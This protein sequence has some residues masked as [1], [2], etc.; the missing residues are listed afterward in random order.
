MRACGR[1][2]G[3]ASAIGRDWCDVGGGGA[4][5]RGRGV[6]GVLGGE[7]KGRGTCPLHSSPG[8]RR[9]GACCYKGGFP[10]C[11]KPILD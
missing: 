3:R 7:I 1:A 2:G 8:K 9:G 6:E 10:V 5:G 4:G 11:S